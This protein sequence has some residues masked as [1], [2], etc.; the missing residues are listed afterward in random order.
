MWF[1]ALAVLAVGLVLA[2]CGG[3]DDAK[4]DK[5]GG[6]DSAPKAKIGLVLPDYTQNELILGAKEGAEA[7]AEELGVELI[8]A[9]GS[10]D[11]TEQVR[12]IEDMV[13]SQVD[14]LMYDA[15]D[16]TGVGPAIKAADEAGVKIVC[17]VSCTDEGNHAARIDFDYETEMGVPTGEWLA[18]A[19]PSA[20]KIGFVDSNQVNPAVAA[21]YDGVRS[22]LSSAGID[23]KL[24]ISPPTDWDKGKALTVA[25]DFLTANPDLDALMCMHDLIAG[26]CLDAIRELDYKKIPVGGEG[27]TCEG[28]TNIVEGR[29]AFT[30]IQDLHPAGAEG[31]R[32]AK[33]LAE[34]KTLTETEKFIPMA[35]VTT[36]ILK[37]IQSGS[38]EAVIN[39][40]DVKALLEGCQK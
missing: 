1:S 38:E 32:M 35:A 3:D 2:A 11:V 9:E 10:G 22:A 12:S 31:V 36:E 30:V 37:G 27:G 15:I 18:E 26:A 16:E 19:V 28:L 24:E 4:T 5:S 21:M 25:R 8:V 23:P 39:G 13:T 7:A 17:I 40:V 34:G 6:G 29:Q 14:V 20:K 33:E